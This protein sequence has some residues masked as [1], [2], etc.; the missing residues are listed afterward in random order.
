[1][2]DKLRTKTFASR[3]LAMCLCLLMVISVAVPSGVF[4]E[5][6]GNEDEWVVIDS[7]GET[8]AETGVTTG[9][10]TVE[11]SPDDYII[12]E[13][14]DLSHYGTYFEYSEKQSD[15]FGDEYVSFLVTAK[16]D[17]TAMIP[18][19]VFLRT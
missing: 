10:E 18:E 6:P 1:M 13:T 11:T 3:V 17:E 5:E 8:E 9:W 14:E 16:C 15:D 2:L 7:Q 19:T 12:T 4:A